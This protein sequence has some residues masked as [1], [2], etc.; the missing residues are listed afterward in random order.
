MTEMEH[1]P[2]CGCGMVEMDEYERFKC[3]GCGVLVKF[4]DSPRQ[5]ENAYHGLVI[6]NYDRVWHVE[7]WNTRALPI[8]DT[9]EMV[10][11]LDDA[12][13]AGR[14]SATDN[15][16]QHTHCCPCGAERTCSLEK[17]H[18]WDDEWEPFG[19][20]CKS[21]EEALPR[22]YGSD[23]FGNVTTPN[24]CPNCGSKAVK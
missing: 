4:P 5:R 18:D 24:Y 2:F 12:Y 11:A 1:C 10:R 22:Y 7:H 20:V 9:P 23:S 19:Y 15:A 6:D 13:E 17:V 3:L 16:T 8:P 21:C 14:K